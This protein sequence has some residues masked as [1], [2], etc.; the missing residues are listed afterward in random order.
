MTPK[1]RF[2]LIIPYFF[3]SAYTT[4][5][6]INIL[7]H[8]LFIGIQIWMSFK[9]VVSPFHLSFF[10]YVCLSIIWKKSKKFCNCYSWKMTLLSTVTAWKHWCFGWTFSLF[11]QMQTSFSV[12]LAL[13]ERDTILQQFMNDPRSSI[14]IEWNV[15]PVVVRFTCHWVIIWAN[16]CTHPWLM[17]C[18]FLN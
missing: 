6:I 2:L 8:V 12:S 1:S 4:Y 16:T 17:K 5:N 13:Q 18:H 11:R 14:T 7:S 15:S 3:S 9:V 10:M